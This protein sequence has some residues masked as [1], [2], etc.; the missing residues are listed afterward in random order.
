MYPKIDEVQPVFEKYL[1]SET[2]KPKKKKNEHAYV[3]NA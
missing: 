2:G 1:Y 3:C